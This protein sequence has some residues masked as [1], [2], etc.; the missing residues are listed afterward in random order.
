MIFPTIYL[1]FNPL[2]RSLERKHMDCTPA[3]GALIETGS[4]Q[5]PHLWGL[6]CLVYCLAQKLLVWSGITVP[7]YL[8]R[9]LIRPCDPADSVVLDI[10]RAY[11][12]KSLG[13][14][15]SRIIAQTTKVLEQD[16]ASCV[17]N[18]LPF[19]KAVPD[20]LLGPTRGWETNHR[21]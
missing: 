16:H 15:S 19:E 5:W 17:R 7:D 4:Q 8:V 18:C 20:V 2:V 12:L 11:N 10:S 21:T 9:F 1:T 6:Q 14:P 13:S 3:Y